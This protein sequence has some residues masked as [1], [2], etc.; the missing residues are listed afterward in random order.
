MLWYIKV[1]RWHCDERFGHAR[2]SSE[3]I[4]TVMTLHT[5]RYSSIPCIRTHYLLDNKT[6]YT[7]E[8]CWHWRNVLPTPPRAPNSQH[9]TLVTVPWAQWRVGPYRVWIYPGYD[10]ALYENTPCIPRTEI[11][12]NFAPLV[13]KYDE[14]FTTAPSLYSS[15]STMTMNHSSPQ[16]GTLYL[17][18]RSPTSS[19]QW[20]TYIYRW[21]TYFRRSAVLLAM[22]TAVCFSQNLTVLDRFAPFYSC[23]RLFLSAFSF[24]FWASSAVRFA[25]TTPAAFFLWRFFCGSF[26]AAP[27]V[28]CSAGSPDTLPCLSIKFC[29][30]PSI[31]RYG[32][33]CMQ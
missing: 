29:W 8:W 19:M 3:G 26:R 5:G 27:Y 28:R 12:K 22:L 23:L 32:N 14:I 15:R 33:N 1:R 21:S 4:C 11:L 25:M 10:L 20:C 31:V 9:K 17:N 13:L 24:I 7:V 16:K 6:P 2:A 18:L 30:D